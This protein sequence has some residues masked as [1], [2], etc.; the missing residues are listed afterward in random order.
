MPKREGIKI[1]AQ[2]RKARHDYFVEESLEAGL[3]LHGTEVKSLRQGKCNLK[4]CFALVKDGEVFVHGMHISPYEQG[5]IYNVD[6][7]RPKKLL[8]H[9][10]EIRRLREQVMQQGY[11]LVPLEVYLKD[12]RMK[13]QLGVCKGK[14]NYDKRDDMARRDAQRE[15][16]RSMRDRG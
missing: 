4:D 6:P 5:N 11:A 10:A 16:E 12:G 1:V 14:K 13:L 15:I 9:K 7:L 8:L 2:N 3:A